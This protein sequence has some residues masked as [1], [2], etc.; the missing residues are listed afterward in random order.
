MEK[1]KGKKKPDLL[2]LLLALKQQKA[3]LGYTSDSA[4][5]GD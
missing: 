2:L 3:I 4:I 5:T 1:M